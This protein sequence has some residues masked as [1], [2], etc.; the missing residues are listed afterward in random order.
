M[1]AKYILMLMFFWGTFTTFGQNTTTIHIA[2]KVEHELT[3]TLD[4]LK[5]LPVVSGKNFKV[6]STSGDIRK[7]FKTYQ[8]VLLTNI[9]DKA[10][11]KVNNPKA[12]GKLIVLVKATDNYTT[13]FSYHEL[14][15]NPTGEQV[16][17]LFEIDNR[18]IAK[19]G[20]FL[21]ISATD[22]ITGA[23]HVKW[24]SEIQVVEL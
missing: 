6:I 23:R 11:I 14:F 10:Q 18:P 1:K 19:D 2:G 16:L 21:L 4:D 5:T 20:P 7:E 24:L 15:N 13:A 3:L 12:K 8:G 22:K 9:L 17:V